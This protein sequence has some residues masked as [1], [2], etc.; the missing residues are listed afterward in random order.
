M[1]KDAKLRPLYLGKVLFEKTDE[2]H[3]L[4]T[5][6]LIKILKEEYNI[7]TYRS[8]L[9]S[10]IKLLQDFGLEIQVVKSTQNKYNLV[11]RAFTIPELKLLID[12]VESSKFIT[13]EKSN[14]LV[15]KLMKL[16]SEKDA[17]KLCRNICVDGKIKTENG[18]TYLIIDAINDA[19]NS[20]KKISFQ[21]VEYDIKRQLRLHNDGEIYIFSPYSLVWDGDNYYVVG[22]SEKHKSIGCHRIDR[23]FRRPEILKDAIVRPP[24]D[25]DINKYV[26]TM[27]RMYSSPRMDVDLICDNSVIDAIIDKFG[28]DVRILAYD[29]QNFRI[30]CNIAVS[31]VFYS[32]V[33]GFEGKVK[34]KGPEKVKQG[35]QETVLRVLESC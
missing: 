32:W 15:E 6:E 12:A 13:Q 2:D 27:F 14:E 22:Y 33:F 24:K 5:T 18:K 26:N 29:M 7:S 19:I 17:E 3:F 9:T 34:I 25:F 1:D 35:F 8:T 4:T 30:I 31:H 16:A 10:D 28:P 23:I 11:D 21:M 20:G